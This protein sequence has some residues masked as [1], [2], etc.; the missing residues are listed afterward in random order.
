MSFHP[1]NV[2]KSLLES[3][4]AV[5]SEGAAGRMLAGNKA[6]QKSADASGE[7][8]M[9][10]RGKDEKGT[11][12]VKKH[13]AKGASEYKEVGNRI[14]EG[15]H[16]AAAMLSEVELDPE[17]QREVEA[18]L[19]ASKALFKKHYGKDWCDV[20]HATIDK[21]SRV[22]A[23]QKAGKA[24]VADRADV[25]EGA[26]SDIDIERKEAK[27][28]P[29]RKVEMT[30]DFNEL[31]SKFRGGKL[32]PAQRRRLRQLSA[33]LGRKLPGGFDSQRSHWQ[34]QQAGAELRARQVTASK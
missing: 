30:K 12:T 34:A 22:A 17:E 2:S 33:A 6:V 29:K 18:A 10:H 9:T 32:D 24:P 11:Y 1:H 8:T 14:Y 27:A 31:L 15:E 4:K 23:K 28:D 13:R 16:D 25:R 5:I 26:F 7:S 21:D 19:E 20:M 3:I